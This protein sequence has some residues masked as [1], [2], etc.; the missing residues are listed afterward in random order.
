MKIKATKVSE[1][2]T[3]WARS[4]IGNLLQDPGDFVMVKRDVPRLIVLRCPCGC[5][6]DLVINLDRRS[7]P[8]WQFYS[9]SGRNSLYPSYWRDTDCGSHFVIWSNR[10]YWCY[11]RSE[12]EEDLDDVDEEVENEVLKVLKTDEYRHYID[13]ADECGLIPWESLQACRQLTARKL[14]VSGGGI[15]TGKFRKSKS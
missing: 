1:K 12:E 10:I 4:A 14:C 9:K 15:L 13:V 6:D 3:V 8:A 7:G 5:G 2:G 11:S